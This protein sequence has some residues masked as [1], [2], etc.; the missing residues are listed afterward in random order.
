MS[1]KARVI[2]RAQSGGNVFYRLRVQGFDDLS[3]ARQ[4]CSALLA[5]QAN[6]IPV[7]TR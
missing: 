7:V 1:D 6:C 3:D 4:F 5:K 2:Q